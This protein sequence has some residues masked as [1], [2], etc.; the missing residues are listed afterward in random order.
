[1][2]GLADA[3]ESWHRAAWCEWLGRDLLIGAFQETG[4]SSRWLMLDYF[5]KH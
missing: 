4:S 3:A 5:S 2:H 1:M